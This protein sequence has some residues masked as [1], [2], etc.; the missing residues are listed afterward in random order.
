MELVLAMYN[1][2][3]FFPQK[4][5]QNIA[6]YSWQNTVSLECPHS[7]GRFPKAL[8]GNYS[9]KSHSC[10]FWQCTYYN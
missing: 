2:H 5:G 7:T 3:P 9:E 10:W 8:H 6:R 1:M 4:F